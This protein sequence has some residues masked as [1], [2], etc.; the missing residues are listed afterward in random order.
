MYIV[1]FYSFKGGVGRTLSLAN[2]GA[3]LAASGRR[4]L[5]V[6]FDLEAPG[7][8]SF[9]L[10]APAAP[11]PGLVEYV[12]SY[13]THNQAPD[14]RE[15]FY[16][17]SIPSEYGKGGLWIMP[18]GLQDASY[19]MRFKAL[20]WDHLYSERDGYL[21]FEDLK[22]QW[23]QAIA[24]DYVLIDSRT[25]HTDTGGICTRQLPDAVVLLFF[26]N[27]QNLEGLRRVAA[28]IRTEA[29]PP[30]Q[31]DIRVHFVAAN[32]PSL[33]DEDRILASRLTE[34]QEALGYESL[35]AVIHHYDSLRLL[36]E[37]LFSIA[38]PGTR[39]SREYLRLQDAIVRENLAD[40]V[41]VLRQLQAMGP[42]RLLLGN[43][44]PN[45]II[46][47]LDGMAA[48]HP[49]DPEVQ[50]AAG[51]LY[52]DLNDSNKALGAISRAIQLGSHRPEAF[53]RRARLYA[54]RNE[55][56]NA[57]ADA[58]AVLALPGTPGTEFLG[59][60]QLLRAYSPETLW[61]LAEQ[62]AYQSLELC[63][64]AKT[65][66][67]LLWDDTLPM[68]NGLVPSV[69]TD[70][71]VAAAHQRSEAC[72][73]LSLSLIATHRFEDAMEVIEASGFDSGQFEIPNRFNYAMAVWG[74]KKH[75]HEESILR[76][77]ALNQQSRTGR[78]KTDPNY[79]QCLAISYWIAG[80][81]EQAGALAIQ[82]RSLAPTHL[83]F[84]SG[85]RYRSVLRAEFLA[86]LDEMESQMSEGTLRPRFLHG[87]GQQE[88]LPVIQ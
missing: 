51:A 53:R 36:N 20:N 80:M 46:R 10:F 39:L 86:D 47:Q 31:K 35:S 67:T 60:V 11:A 32:V 18:A 87:D 59:A 83:F 74:A 37:E 7:L 38:R 54:S 75:P 22:E 50:Y 63:D 79:A 24:P 9:P 85:W 19:G 78:Q 17:V 81:Q 6:D 88:R 27:P 82:A 48:A 73:S 13:V 68:V 42:E 16:R 25:G 23:Q 72:V 70:W 61:S 15:Y 44:D 28:E 71:R 65:L 29:T 45:L 3:A 66:E 26:P 76:V 84:L 21:L 43:H 41:G 2:I 30:R 56:E 62:P 77:M 52:D 4:V 12:S 69:L 34:F 40:R 64:R 14:A 8:Q 49:Q 5:L 55:A 58:R 57:A 1:T 33:D